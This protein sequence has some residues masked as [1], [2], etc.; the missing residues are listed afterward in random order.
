MK[1]FI[2]S[3]VVLFYWSLCGTG[4]WAQQEVWIQKGIWE[5]GAENVPVIRLTPDTIWS[6]QNKV[7]SLTEETGDFLTVH[8]LDS[9]DHTW[10]IES[11]GADDVVIPAGGSA[12]LE[13][14]ALA[15]GCYRLGLSDLSGYRLGGSS[16]L[17]VGLPD[18]AF[19]STALYHWNLSDW[20]T[21]E[22][23]SIAAGEIPDEEAPY[24]PTQFTIN[25]RTYPATVEDPNALVQLNLGDSCLIAIA[26]HGLMDHVL[27]FHGFH[28]S[29]VSST[30]HPERVGWSKDTVPVRKGEG[31]TVQLVANQPG[32]YPVHDHNLIAVTNAGFYPGGMLTQIIV[33]P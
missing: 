17:Q 33:A 14:P 11:S 25:E 12:E 27:H 20:S 5:V 28:V 24:V 30:H 19:D 22:M 32:T 1:K 21:A 23:M 29:I 13:L 31:L 26:N 15:M 8:N 7:F 4:V 16:M 2:H 10:F 3:L 9:L 6:D 18:I